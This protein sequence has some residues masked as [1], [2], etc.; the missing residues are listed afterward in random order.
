MNKQYQRKLDKIISKLDKIASKGKDFY[1]EY[2]NYVDEL[3][4]KGEYSNFVNALDIHYN[5]DIVNAIDV[6]TAKQNSWSEICFQTK[7][8]FLRRL[9]NLY[10]QKKVYQQSTN[11]YSDDL[12]ITQLSLSNKYSATFSEIGLSPSISFDRI[13]SNI[14]VTID[15]SS[16]DYIE[17]ERSK[18]ETI[19]GIYQPV[20]NRF[21]Q[22]LYISYNANSY[23]EVNVDGISY[24]D[25]ITFSITPQKAYEQYQLLGITSS[26]HFIEGYV[27]SYNKANGNLNI[28]VESFTGSGT[29]S[30]WVI[31]YLSGTQSPEYKTE[32]SVDFAS[33]YVVKTVYRDST[34]YN[35]RLNITKD[36]FLGTIEEFDTYSQNAKYL[37][38]D[39]QYA[40]LIGERKYYL[41]VTKVGAT[42]SFGVIYDNPSLSE[43]SNLLERYRLAIDYLLS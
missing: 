39:K 6:N 24:G 1:L 28:Q 5:I 11:I 42:Q 16:I 8:S 29:N 7:D 4:Q 40:R 23:T 41:I 19:D 31:N 12:N 22:D 30:I 25:Y 38:Q 26:N 27:N 3:I 35:Y 10:K 32:I 14:F 20:D 2:S 15:D 34:E 13:D 37:L 17:I 43:D 18:W 21:I 36:P 33:E 9:S